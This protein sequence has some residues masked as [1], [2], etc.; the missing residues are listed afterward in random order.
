MDIDME[1]KENEDWAESTRIEQENDPID[2]IDG[3]AS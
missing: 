1:V 2:T 3:Y